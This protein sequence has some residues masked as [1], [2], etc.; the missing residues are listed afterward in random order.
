MNLS[1]PS[2]GFCTFSNRSLWHMWF[3]SGATEELFEVS[4]WPNQALVE[5]GQSLTVN[6]STTC[7]ELGPSGIE[8][9]LKKTKWNSVLQCFFSCA[10]IQKDISLGIT[11]YEPPK[12]VILE[13]QPTWVAMDET[14]T[15]TC[16]VPSVASLE[17]LTLTLLQGNEELYR[18][19][20][21]SLAVASQRAEVTI[22]SSSPWRGTQHGPMPPFGQWR[23]VTR[24]C[25]A[26]YLWGQWNRKQES[27]CLST[28]G[29]QPLPFPIW[30]LCC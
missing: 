11:V 10:G 4:V 23:L 17:N 29:D 14:F 20:F 3:I 16:H 12:E 26:L 19:N 2:W 21:V 8:T 30:I 9:F 5:Y 22:T 15:V 27:Q 6:C 1:S 25:P 7:P 28:V 24:S 13:L 18:N